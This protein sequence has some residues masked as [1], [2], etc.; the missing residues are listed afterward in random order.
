MKRIER[1]DA[2][3]RLVQ[4]CNPKELYYKDGGS[5]CKQCFEQIEK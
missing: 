4:R 5:Y 3:N 2:C 1:C